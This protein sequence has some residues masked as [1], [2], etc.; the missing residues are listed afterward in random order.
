MRHPRPTSAASLALAALLALTACESN[1]PLGPADGHDGAFDVTVTRDAEHVHTLGHGVT[2]TVEVT[3]H[4][5]N[6][7]TDFEALALER[8][9]AGS[10]SWR[11]IEMEQAGD[12]YQG[13]YVFATSG[14]YELRV[15]AQEHGAESMET[16]HEVHDPLHVGRAHADLGPWRV[17]FESFPGH[18]HEGEEAAL[19]FWV[20]EE[21][22]DGESHPVEGLTPQVHVRNEATG[23]EVLVE[24]E[25][26]EAGVYEV[27]HHFEEAGEVHGGLHAETPS[28]EAGEAAFHFE[29]AHGH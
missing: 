19:R 21:H 4:D 22:E 1:P 26:H 8:K 20:T 15:M 13:T 28:G 11:A 16:I 3:D 24:A 10:D 14:E 29:V 9:L 2:F 18:V 23:Q 17:E 6:P 5:G 27:H 25:E 7:V 12:V